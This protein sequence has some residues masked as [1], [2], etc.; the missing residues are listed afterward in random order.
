MSEN[1]QTNSTRLLHSYISIS[2]K[3]GD[4]IEERGRATIF[5][6]PLSELVRHSVVD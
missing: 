4:A 1:A 5:R 2:S 3:M 6:P